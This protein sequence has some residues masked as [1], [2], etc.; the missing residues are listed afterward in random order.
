MSSC[1]CVLPI[2]WERLWG[3]LVPSWLDLLAGRLTTQEFYVRRVPLGDEILE[4]WGL[5]TGPPPPAPGPGVRRWDRQDI[6]PVRR[7]VLQRRG[8]DALGARPAIPL[9]RAG[10]AEYIAKIRRIRIVRRQ[11]GSGDRDKC[12]EC[13]NSDGGE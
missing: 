2:D 13:H 10:R 5:G 7:E 8:P 9:Q 4:V 12:Q 11:H 1:D 6:S 3:D